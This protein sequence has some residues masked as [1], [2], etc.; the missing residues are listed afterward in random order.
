MNMAQAD[1]ISLWDPFN[2]FEDLP[3]R[4]LSNL[5]TRIEPCDLAGLKDHRIE[6]L[7]GR[8]VLIATK[9][10][11]KAA[12]ALI[13]LDGIARRLVL[14]PPDLSS[15]HLLHVMI[16]AG[17]E[18]MVSD[19][20]DSL[21]EPNPERPNKINANKC[22]E[23][24]WILLT[25]GTTDVPKLVKHALSSLTGA[26]K[27]GAPNTQGNQL[28]WSTFYDI[29]RYGGL[30]IFSAQFPEGDRWC[31][32]I[33]LTRPAI[34]SFVGGAVSAA[35]VV[36]ILSACP[37]VN[38]A[39]VY[40]VPITGAEGRAGMAAVVVHDDFN[41]ATLRC[42]L[43]ERLPEYARPLFLRIR[44]ELETTRP[45]DRGGRTSYLKASIH[46]PQGIQ[47]T[48]TILGKRLS[49]DSTQISMNAFKVERCACD[50]WRVGAV[51]RVLQGSRD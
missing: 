13:E 5:E 25:S 34:F 30:Q 22:S 4:F 33:P 46:L 45:L 28:I 26:L 49:C 32:R 44:S 16:T 37:G 47:S 39:L 27:K 50:A 10:Q 3:G 15:E 23:T 38:Q 8:S 31:A 51:P 9:D 1:R 18:A 2:K 35:E 7:R 14:S 17:V 6:S 21:V 11:L 36:A 24:E 42:H 43:N 19:S 12:V 41:L 40:G 20:G 29:R 48:S